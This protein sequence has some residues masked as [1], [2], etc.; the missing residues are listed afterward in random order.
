LYLKTLIIKY[1]FKN[2]KTTATKKTK[3][4]PKMRR[5]R[6]EEI[7][8]KLNDTSRWFSH[9]RGIS[10]EVLG[11]EL[12]LLIEDI[13]DHADVKEA[14]DAYYG[15]LANYLGTIGASGALHMAGM[16]VPLSS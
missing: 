11:R 2:W 3:V 1:K 14:I 8:R 15:L 7:G 10:M 9:G 16:L 6:A 13:D 4:T 5:D 12:N